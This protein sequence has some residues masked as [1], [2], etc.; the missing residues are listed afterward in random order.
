MSKNP[1]PLVDTFRLLHKDASDVGTAHSFK[2]GRA[3]NKID[4]IFVQPGTEVLQAEILHDN[5]DNRYP[6]DHFPITAAIRFAGSGQPNMN[7]VA[8]ALPML[9]QDV[10]LR[11]RTF[12]RQCPIGDW[13]RRALLRDDITRRL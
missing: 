6:S 4:Y 7:E 2:G 5:K 10:C 9:R 11:I 3:G 1:L 12:W 13:L 8:T